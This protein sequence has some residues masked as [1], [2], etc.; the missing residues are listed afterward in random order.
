M[1]KIQEGDDE[2][3]EIMV[4]ESQYQDG[5]R[6][7]DPEQMPKLRNNFRKCKFWRISHKQWGSTLV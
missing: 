3:L 1:S 5:L 7:W 6:V 4:F 2:F